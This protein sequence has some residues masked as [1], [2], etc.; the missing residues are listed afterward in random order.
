MSEFGIEQQEHQA[1]KNSP[2]KEIKQPA[3]KVK[4]PYPVLSVDL[5]TTETKACLNANPE[6][7]EFIPAYVKEL[8]VNQVQGVIQPFA[9]DVYSNLTVEYRGKGYALGNRAEDEQGSLGLTESKVAHAVVKVLGI[10]TLFELT[11]DV[12]L[13]IGLPYLSLEQFESEREQLIEALEFQ[14][15][16]W[17]FRKETKEISVQEVFVIPEGFCSLYWA[18]QSD[19]KAPPFEKTSV[20]IIDIGHRTTD[21]LSVNRFNLAV[22]STLSIPFAMSEFYRRVGERIGFG[23]HES[24]CLI[25]AVTALE[26]DR[27]FR[28]KGRRKGIDLD[29]VLPSLRSTFAEEVCD[30]VI[31]WLPERTRIVCV[32]GGGGK[33]FWQELKELFLEAGLKPYLIEPCR[34]ATALG[35]WL[36]GSNQLI[37][38]HR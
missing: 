38:Q 10:V 4:L 8:S 13:V 1:V 16:V 34:K 2:A 25:Q 24:S 20:A 11:G 14:T 17:N 5:G 23:N 35:Q 12:A 29:E 37:K 32:V 30:R 6:Y 19:A 15:K 3:T 9:S 22:G 27:F 36:Y 21:M 28:P 26:G 18:Q 7:V 33:Y 31:E